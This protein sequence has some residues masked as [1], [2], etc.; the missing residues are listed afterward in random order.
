MNAGASVDS[1][2]RTMGTSSPL[3]ALALRGRD[4]RVAA[5]NPASPAMIF[6]RYQVVL[7]SSE[8]GRMEG[9]VAV[10]DSASNRHLLL[11]PVTFEDLL[12][13]MRKHEES[14]LIDRRS[15]IEEF[16]EVQIDFFRHEVSRAGQP[17]DL[18]AFEFKV[19]RFF[20]SNP[21]RVISRD[22]LLETVWG[23][24][25]YPTTRTVDNKILRLRQKLELDPAKPTHFQTVY[26]VGYKFVP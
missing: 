8:T 15:D 18:T 7:I 24:N 23:Y 3:T 9:V 4:G 14:E 1:L 21:C 25:C 26:G 6:G 22:E 20:L 19:M 10:E 5:L 16:G 12:N 17:V 11:L 2:V 13:Q